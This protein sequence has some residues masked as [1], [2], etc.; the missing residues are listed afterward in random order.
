MP[1]LSKIYLF[2]MAFTMTP[3]INVVIP[4][5]LTF[6]KQVQNIEKYLY[7]VLQ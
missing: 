1:Y 4:K 3:G 7:Q 6:F 2:P 5:I